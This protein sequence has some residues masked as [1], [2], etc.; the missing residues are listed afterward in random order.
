MLVRNPSVTGTGDPP[1]VPAPASVAA[2]VD[3]DE[4]VEQ[5]ASRTAAPII[6]AAV[7]RRIYYLISTVFIGITVD[8]LYIK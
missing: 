6:A 2:L 5:P 8:S 1:P 3:E 4:E 7:T